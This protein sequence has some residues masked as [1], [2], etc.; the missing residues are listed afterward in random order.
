MEEKKNISENKNSVLDSFK[1]YS[2]SL[3]LLIPIISFGL[4]VYILDKIFGEKFYFMISGVFIGFIAVN[5][6]IYRKMKSLVD[7]YNQEKNKK[8]NKEN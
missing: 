2:D 1:V 5:F 8:E 4:Y 3:D 7:K 6:A